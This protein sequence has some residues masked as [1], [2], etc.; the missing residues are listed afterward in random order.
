MIIGIGCDLAEVSRIKRA[1]GM[2]GFAARVFTR[3][4]QDYCMARGAQAYASF[5]ARFAAKEAFVKAIGTG[6]RGGR[7]TEIE[8]INDALG[9]PQLVLY[10]YFKDYAKGQLVL[11]GYF[12]DYA[13][14]LGTEKIHLTL[15]HTKELAMAQV[16]LEG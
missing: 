1:L 7:L 5:A 14:G 8:V 3:R 10:G 2:K 12:K 11:Y 4:E 16:I 6:L 9:R 15:S 13:K